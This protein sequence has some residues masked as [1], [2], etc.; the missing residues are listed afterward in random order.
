[1]RSPSI[2]YTIKQF[3]IE[4]KDTTSKLYLTAVDGKSNS[5]ARDIATDR[6][7]QTHIWHWDLPRT[8]EGCYHVTGGV[9]PAVKQAMAFAPFVDLI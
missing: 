3:A 2:H 8:R 1:M 7:Q 6:P 9:E 5:E 4:D